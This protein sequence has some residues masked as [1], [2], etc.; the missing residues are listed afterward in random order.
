MA[1]DKSARGRAATGGKDEG[2]VHLEAAYWQ[3]IVN[4]ALD[5]V[6]CI[7]GSGRVTLFNPTAEKMFGYPAREAIGRNVSFLMPSPYREE[8]DDYIRRYQ[9]S[10][11]PRAIGRIRQVTAQRKDGVAFPIELSVSEA[12][13]GEE[14]LY[15]ATIRDVTERKQTEEALATRVRQQAVVSDLG[16]Q[17]LAGTSP[18]GLMDSAVRSVAGVLGAEYCEILELQPDASLLLRAG[19]GWKDGLVG[20]ATVPDVGSQASYTL[21]ANAPVIVDDLPRETR[22]RGPDLLL[23]HGVV[24]GLSVVIFGRERPFGVLGA[25]TAQRRRFTADDTHFLQGVANVIAASVDRVGAEQEARKFQLLAQQRERLADIGAIAADVA[26]DLGNPVAAL[27]LQAEL[28]IRRAARDPSAPVETLLGPAQRIVAEAHRLDRLV[29]EVKGFARQQ[30]LQC[31]VV[32]LPEL[33]RSVVDMW[34]PM[35][36]ARRI[37]LRLDA[38]EDLPVLH[39]DEDKLRRVLDNL[40]KNAVEAIE[41]GPGQ[42]RLSA[43]TLPGGDRVRISVQDSGPGIPPD[44]DVFRLF[45]TTKRDG[46]GLGLSIARQIALAH[47]GDLT[48]EAAEPHGTIFHLDLPLRLSSL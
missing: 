23:E 26:H 24:S 20:H 44:V 42:I 12:R 35:A 25:H 1:R 28:L 22:F 2:A 39:A 41:Q 40:I 30:R 15:A 11:V 38:P 3:A 21:Q 18:S 13:V 37:F 10:H 31:V 33:L 9:Q 17:A 45:E 16:L 47:A 34:R 4:T 27:S 5:A 32:A 14:V 6:I 48:V 7:D 19:V 43:G 46:S 36:G 8:H 29:S